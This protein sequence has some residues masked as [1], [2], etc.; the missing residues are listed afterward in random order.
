MTP[1]V[2]QVL[3]KKKMNTHQKKQWVKPPP[4]QDEHLLYSKDVA[5]FLIFLGVVFTLLM[6]AIYA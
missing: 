5:G 2:T 4:A 1:I 6:I 3:V